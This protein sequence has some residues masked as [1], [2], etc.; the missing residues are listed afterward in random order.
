MEQK[1]DK[2]FGKQV[3]EY[4]Q[5]KPEVYLRNDGTWKMIEAIKDYRVMQLTPTR[6]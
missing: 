1:H 5:S 6:G 2:T 4:M 3:M